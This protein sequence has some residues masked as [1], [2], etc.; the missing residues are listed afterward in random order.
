MLQ[1]FLPHSFS[2]NR[3]NCWMHITL[4]VLKTLALF[5][6]YLLNGIRCCWLLYLFYAGLALPQT[7][8]HTTNHSNIIKGNHGDFNRKQIWKITTQSKFIAKLISRFKASGWKFISVLLAASNCFKQTS[9]CK[10]EK[11]T[12]IRRLIPVSPKSTRMQCSHPKRYNWR[13]CLSRKRKP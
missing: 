7:C 2:H 8:I 4:C 10:A 6:I 5:L 9:L 13:V 12:A 11:K 1:I 3:M